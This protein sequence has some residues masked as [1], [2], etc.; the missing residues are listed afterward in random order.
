MSAYRIL[1]I[2]DDAQIRAMMQE[3]LTRE[4]YDIMAGEN[5]TAGLKLL[6]THIFDGALIDI[7]LP[8]MA[9]IEVLEELK[10]R[11]PGV[12]AVMM[13]G[14]PQVET[15]VQALRLGAYDY[16]IKP[17][18]WVSLRHL[19]KRMV[20]H[21]YLRAEVTSLRNRLSDHPPIG[22]LIGSSPRMQELREMI[23]KVAPT[24][25]VVR[26]EG[27]SGTGKEL[28]AGAI[29]RLSTR[30]RGAFVPVNC[31]AI[32]AELMES[33]L[34]GHVKGAFSGASGDSSGLFRAAEGGTIFLDEIGELPLQMQPK[35]LRVLQE[36]E[37]RPVGSSHVHRVDTRVIAATNQRLDAAVRNG[38]FREDLFF[39]LN[40]IRTEAPPLREIKEDIPRIAMNFVR[41]LNHRFGR[42][43]Q[44]I[45][46]EALAALS[47][48]AFPGNVRELENII[49][50]AYALGA[51]GRIAVADLPSLAARS[52]LA[53]ASSDCADLS[54]IQDGERQ[55]IADTLRACGTDRAAAARSLGISERTLYR[56]LKRSG[57]T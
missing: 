45:A 25:S 20:E 3:E 16:L 55:L 1:L 34:F 23:A 51:D 52:D 54:T 5:G 2:E 22:E 48:Y 8:D 32:P 14:Y 29:H 9:G 30:S 38:K 50:R 43:V 4:G 26:I 41:V 53:P 7:N 12:D 27:E 10:R 56:R 46:P 24:D 11:D 19:L 28:I 47:Q 49:E 39:R 33:E 21:R 31:A 42:H 13:T 18:D 40:V 37:V 15:A 36:K 57:L 35:L 44:S 17:F 6:Q